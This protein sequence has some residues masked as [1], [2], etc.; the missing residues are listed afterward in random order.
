[1]KKIG[2]GFAFAIV[3]F[4]LIIGGMSVNYLSNSIF[5]KNLP[6]WAD[7][8]IGFFAGELSVPAAVVVWILKA[9][10]VDVSIQ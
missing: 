1:M 2:C 4:N 7:V 6:M 3:V 5:H 9:C 10:G 8:L